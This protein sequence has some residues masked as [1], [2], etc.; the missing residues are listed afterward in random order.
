LPD[1]SLSMS[2][3]FPLVHPANFVEYQETLNYFSP[4]VGPSAV[5]GGVFQA[6]LTP[7]FHLG[8]CWQLP[9]SCRLLPLPLISA[10]FFLCCSVRPAAVHRFPKP[11]YGGSIVAYYYAQS[12]RYNRGRACFSPETT[13]IFLAAS[14][15][16]IFRFG[17]VPHLQTVETASDSAF[18]VAFSDFCLIF[19]RPRCLIPY[20]ELFPCKFPPLL[21][22]LGP[23]TSRS[24]NAYFL[25]PARRCLSQPLFCCRTLCFTRKDAFCTP[26]F[27]HQEFSPSMPSDACFRSPSPSHS[28]RCVQHSGPERLSTFC[29]HACHSLGLTMDRFRGR[30]SFLSAA[31]ISPF[32]SFFSFPL[33]WNVFSR[34]V[35]LAPSPVL[36]LSLAPRR[37]SQ[38]F[39]LPILYSA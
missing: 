28:T 13:Q 11:P 24:F 1:F 3:P 18:S 23:A 7:P 10:I 15:A 16:G 4:P 27:W 5:V 29:K 31:G 38:V 6:F 39:L 32:S 30:C 26:R 12:R 21:R 8:I 9:A 19:L 17:P 2:I 34:S 25:F 14:V 33:V 20:R 36:Q 35:R 22:P 37:T